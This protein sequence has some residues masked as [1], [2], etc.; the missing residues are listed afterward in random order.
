MLLSQDLY[1]TPEEFKSDSNQNFLPSLNFLDNSNLNFLNSRDWE[2]WTQNL[3][4]FGLFWTI[5][6]AVIFFSNFYFYY[7]RHGDMEINREIIGEKSL[8]EIPKLWQR[9]LVCWFFVFLVNL[10]SG[11][12]KI[13]IAVITT[14]SF[15]IKFWLDL[16]DFLKIS[17][18]FPWYKDFSCKFDKLLSLKF[19]FFRK[20]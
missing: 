3:N 2:N 9:Y 4:R 14:I 13:L 19:T 10:N 7:R 15:L 17:E 18:Y 8:R 5:F 1:T 12:L 16:K 6:L 11:I 20:K